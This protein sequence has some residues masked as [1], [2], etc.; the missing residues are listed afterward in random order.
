ARPL[1]FTSRNL[2][3]FTSPETSRTPT[4]EA[5]NDHR[6]P[7]THSR[8]HHRRPPTIEADSSSQFLQFSAS[9]QRATTRRDDDQERR[10]LKRL[11]LSWE[12]NRKK[13]TPNTNL[14]SIL[15]F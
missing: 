14:P 10:R 4:I 7:S 6:R 11:A 12:K 5:T 1:N 8:D 2:F 13:M 9:Q 15:G 3:N